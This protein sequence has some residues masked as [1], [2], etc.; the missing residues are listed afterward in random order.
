M[1]VE[2]VADRES[3]APKR[4]AF[5]KRGIAVSQ[6]NKTLSGEYEQ[7]GEYHRQPDKKW[8]YYP[9]YVQKMA[10]VRKYLDRNTRQAKIADLGCGEGILVEEYRQRGFNILGVDANYS[11]DCVRNGDITALEFD[12]QSLDLVLAL[13]VIEHLDFAQQEAAIREIKRVLRPQGRALLTIPNLAHF[14]SRVTFA[15]TG[16][17]L[18]TATIDR[19]KG[20]RP[21]GEYLTLCRRQGLKV[22]RRRGLFPTLPLISILTF[23]A[24]SRVVGLHAI[25]NRLLA[26]PGVCFLNIL[27]LQ[28]CEN[29]LTISPQ[30]S[31][32]RRQAA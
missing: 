23:L 28:P 7:R 32:P 16:K 12:D 8:H 10:F 6:N 9:V 5:F 31:S 1:V 3:A 24:P 20:D 29:G 30:V 14:A 15:L 22:V 17:L 4:R 21:I 25:Y 27:E 18:R 19:H 11:S 2:C 26:L 13:D